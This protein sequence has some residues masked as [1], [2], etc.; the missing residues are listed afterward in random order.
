[1]LSKFIKKTRSGEQKPSEKPSRTDRFVEDDGFWFFK[2]REGIDVG[3][4][5]ERSDAEYALL[6]FVEQA[7]WPTD[8]QLAGFIEGCKLNSGAA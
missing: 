2:T 3:P 7:E 1:M 6:Y 5:D 8:E 4:F